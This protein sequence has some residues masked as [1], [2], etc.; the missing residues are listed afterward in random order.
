MNCFWKAL[1][2][3]F[4]L[5]VELKKK[6]SKVRKAPAFCYLV[7]G[8]WI[9]CRAVA[10]NQVMQSKFCAK[11]PCRSLVA[12]KINYYYLRQI[13]VVQWLSVRTSNARVV[14][15]T[16]VNKT[17]LVGKTTG[18]YLMKSAFLE[19]AQ[20]PVSCFCYGRNRACNAVCR[21]SQFILKPL[22]YLHI[23][24]NPLGN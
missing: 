1:C 22:C 17:P 14:N 20:S 12:G 23:W 7:G 9:I 21:S 16:R 13:Y 4:L 18:K 15:S 10:I 24:N 8:P 6:W 19:K 5:P 11:E 2:E 3:L